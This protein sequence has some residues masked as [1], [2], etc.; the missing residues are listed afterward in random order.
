[1]V[2]KKKKRQ[3]KERN[4]FYESNKVLLKPKENKIPEEKGNQR[5][6]LDSA[7]IFPQGH[8]HGGMLSRL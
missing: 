4:H 8:L 3:I 7:A 1:M 5:G 6:E 2:K